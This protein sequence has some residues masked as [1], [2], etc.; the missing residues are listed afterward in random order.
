M[1]HFLRKL[2]LR[3]FRPSQI[4]A[5]NF[6]DYA[7]DCPWNHFLYEYGSK[8]LVEVDQENRPLYLAYMYDSEVM[9][10]GHLQYFLNR[11]SDPFDETIAALDAIGATVFS[12]ILKDAT[13]RWQSQQRENSDTV[14]E[15]IS[16]ALEDEFRDY[17]GRFY[18]TKP[19]IS[20]Y[21]ED[22]LPINKSN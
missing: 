1:M 3:I 15:Y 7:Y 20:K 12:S 9:N 22:L 10:G 13:K 18:S 5:P 8:E 17:G 2:Y 11:A 14:E 19:E 21:I 4:S 6:W 16:E